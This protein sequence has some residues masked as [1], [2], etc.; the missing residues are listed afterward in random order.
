[1]AGDHLAFAGG[2][3]GGAAGQELDQAG[4]ASAAPEDPQNAG[5]ARKVP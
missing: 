4:H 3:V 1:M 2:P 5:P